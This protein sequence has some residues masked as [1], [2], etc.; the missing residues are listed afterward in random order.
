MIDWS[1]VGRASVGAALLATATMGAGNHAIAQDRE[2]LK[3]GV[4]TFLSGPAAGHFGVPARNGI[5]LAI[6]AINAGTLP[7]PYTGQGIAGAQVE[8]IYI[9][10]AGGAT[11]QVSEFRNLVQRQN[12][13]LVLGYISSG[14]CLAIPAVADELKQ[15]TVLSDCGTPRVFEEASY[16]YVFRTGPHAVMDN[17]AAA[18]YMLDRNP[19]IQSI[20]GI[21]Q[22]YA[23]GQDSW[24]DFSESMIALK[25]GIEIVTSQFP[26]I[27]AGEYNSEI[28]ALLVGRPDVIHSS[29]WGADLEAFILQGVGRGLYQQS[30]VMLSAGEQI[31]PRIGKQLPDGVVI[32]ARGPHGDFARDSALNDWFKAA[33]AERYDTIPNYAAYKFVQTVLGVKAAY[34]KAAETAGG[35]PDQEQVVAAFEYLE[36]EGPSGKVSMALGNGHQAIQDNAIGISKYDPEL[37]RMT[38]TDIKYYAAECVNPPADMKGIDWIRAGFPGAKCE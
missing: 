11:K 35:F 13:D 5:E 19:E 7:A 23:W 18:R 28:T 30:S 17:V 3:I 12:V 16:K 15:L 14:D 26:K 32:G 22:N 25:P 33:Y 37:G 9:D 10:E 29:L 2:S 20:A 1:C 4:V 36:W 31:F 38:V 8:A 6:E 34:E 21:N 24:S 27:F